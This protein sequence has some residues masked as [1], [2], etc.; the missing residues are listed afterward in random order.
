[1][2][3]HASRTAPLPS[4]P[5]TTGLHRIIACTCGMEDEVYKYSLTTNRIELWSRDVFTTGIGI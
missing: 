4:T 2:V 1:M 3:L 5:A